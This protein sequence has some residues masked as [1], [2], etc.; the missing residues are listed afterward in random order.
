M[1]FKVS[2]RTN[3]ET[4]VYSGYYRL[5]E[6]YRNQ[7][8]RVCHR[9]LLNAGYLDALNTD[10]LNLIQK[11]LTAKVNN[12]GK[13]LFELS[14]SSDE[15]VIH[16]VEMFYKRMVAEKRIDVAGDKHVK[17]ASKNGKDLHL[18]DINSIRNKD[19][20]EIGTEWMLQQS[21]QQLQIASFLEQQGLSDGDIKLAQSHIIARAAYPA[22]ELETARWMKE[23]SSVCEVTG[24]DINKITKDQLYRISKKLYGE[25]EALE[26]HLSLRTNE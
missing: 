5:V 13:P 8:D 22:S 3:P 21:M 2:M 16:Y 18:I 24:Y 12:P 23:N 15:V 26:Q 25:K 11:I 7:N 20:R 10:Q 17:Q 19:V 6:S 9:T 14:C 4:G 1:Y